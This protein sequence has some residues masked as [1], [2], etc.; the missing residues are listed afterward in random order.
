MFHSPRT[1]RG[2]GRPYRWE[3]VDGVPL[4]SLRA[5]TFNELPE[6]LLAQVFQLLVDD[7]APPKDEDSDSF[8]RVAPTLI[9]QQVSRAWR[10][11]ALHAPRAWCYI[12]LDFTTFSSTPNRSRAYLRTLLTRSG[13]VPLHIRL[14]N[15]LP[16][17]D[18][19][20]RVPDE[21]A[22]E[23]LQAYDWL[24]CEAALDALVRQAYRWKTFEFQCCHLDSHE[25]RRALLGRIHVSAPLLEELS[26][27]LHGDAHTGFES[28][29]AGTAP[30]LPYAPRLR[31][32]N[33]D[34]NFLAYVHFAGL[35]KLSS[36]TFGGAG[37]IVHDLS[38]ALATCMKLKHLRLDSSVPMDFGAYVPMHPHGDTPSTTRA[39]VLPAL[40]DLELMNGQLQVLLPLADKLF[41]PALRNVTV[42]PMNSNQN[43]DAQFKF[44]KTVCARLRRIHLTLTHPVHQP[45]SLSDIVKAFP[46]VEEVVAENWTVDARDFQELL[47]TGVGEQLTR[48]TM[49]D[50]HFSLLGG[51]A[52]VVMNFAYFLGVRNADYQR[53]GPPLILD[54]PRQLTIPESVH[55]E[56]DRCKTPTPR[57]STK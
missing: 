33:L 13:A 50:C 10:A 14:Y 30:L 18:P 49:P 4:Q 6:E 36:I 47:R 35:Q 57:R 12:D 22:E 28:K 25:A 8:I 21:A 56:L 3:Y 17:K 41:L 11:A 34:H 5:P 20:R 44:L 23:F 15:Y 42:G 9:V 54:L 7:P 19:G 26:L 53:W 16:P 48:L 52:G 46:D 39:V 2:D 27:Q 1:R 24:G 51:V 55:T 32:V 29:H 38:Y 37:Y 40:T 45:F 43:P 31:A